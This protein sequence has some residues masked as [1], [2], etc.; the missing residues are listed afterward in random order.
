MLLLGHGG[1]YDKDG[2]RFVRLCRRYAKASGLAVVCIDA[3]AHGVRKAESSIP[4]PPPRQWHSSTSSQ[5]VRDWQKTAQT[6]EE[7][8]PPVAYVGFSMGALFGFPT[9][10]AMPSIRAAVFVVSGYPDGGG[11][12]DEPLNDLLTDSATRLQHA[13]VLMLNT[14]NDHIFPVAG[15]HQLFNTTRAA[16]KQLS[17]WEGE[18]DDW[19]D[20]LIANSESFIC[21][22]LASSA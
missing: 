18:H 21:N 13:S 4:G 14:T 7:I 3:V 1:G 12:D 6:L 5:M 16:D 19:S 15:V 8:G 10:A 17:F 2:S 20:E 11:I 9:V 22:R